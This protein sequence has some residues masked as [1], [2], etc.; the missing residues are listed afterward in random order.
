[1]A[2]IP[3]YLVESFIKLNTL[4]SGFA[5]VEEAGRMAFIDTIDVNLWKNTSYLVALELGITAFFSPLAV[6]AATYVTKQVL[7]GKA[8]NRSEMLDVAVG[9]I[10]KY[11]FTAVVLYSILLTS[12]IFVIPFIFFY[13]AFYFS[14]NAV[15]DEGKWGI[16][17]FRKSYSIVK[18]RWF[19]TLLFILAIFIL[20]TIVSYFFITGGSIFVVIF[21][22]VM[23]ELFCLWFVVAVCVKYFNLSALQQARSNE[24]AA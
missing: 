1:M 11:L 9:K 6:G 13:V 5:N 16:G 21:F 20:R 4:M 23:D 14:Q 8:I 19:K 22:A 18:G 24:K 15:A 2:L 10:G 7:Q 17:A 12:F 3:Q